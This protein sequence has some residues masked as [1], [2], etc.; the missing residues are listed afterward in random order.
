MQHN[1]TGW[2][3][4]YPFPCS[5]DQSEIQCVSSSQQAEKKGILEIIQKNPRFTFCTVTA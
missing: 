2:G 1:Y 5:P 4:L 3:C